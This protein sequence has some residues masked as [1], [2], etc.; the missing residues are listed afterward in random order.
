M[1]DRRGRIVALSRGQV[2]R[3]FLDNAIDRGAAVVRRA[4]ALLVLLLALAP[5]A[6]P[7]GAAA[8]RASFNDVE[9][10]LMCDTCN[11]PLNIAES[12]R[13][14]QERA[15]DPHADRARA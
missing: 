9:D 1:I 15:R 4:G 13:A 6:A 2:T 10:E 7:A 5:A 14:D 3:Q 11:V 8:P 12:P